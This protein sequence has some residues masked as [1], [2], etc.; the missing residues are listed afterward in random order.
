MPDEDEYEVRCGGEPVAW[1]VGEGALIDA[2]HYAL[3][4]SAD[5]PVEIY[6]VHK[7]YILIETSTD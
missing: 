2:R 4:Y 1:T 7:T 5:G 3:F 6:K